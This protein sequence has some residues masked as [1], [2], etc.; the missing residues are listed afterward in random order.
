MIC[1]TS[2]ACSFAKI[3]WPETVRLFPSF[4]RRGKEAECVAAAGDY[5]FTG[6]WK[7]RG[8][9]GVNRL[10]DGSAAGDFDPGETVGGNENTGLDRYSHR[11]HRSQAQGWRISG[12]R[13]GRLQSQIT[14]VSLEPGIEM[15]SW[16]S[17]KRAR[18]GA[19]FLWMLTTGSRGQSADWQ[20]VIWREP[21]VRYLLADMTGSG[22]T[23]LYRKYAP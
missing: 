16:N 12:V 17:N 3:I 11:H 21:Q 23:D 18:I 13:G 10:S 14:D 8:R 20:N 19:L 6:G 15:K 9:I 1:G 7:E 22:K 5:V 4:R 2:T